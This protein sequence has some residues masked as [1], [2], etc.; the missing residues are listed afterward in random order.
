M[1]GLRL[2]DVGD[3][4]ENLKTSLK[5]SGSRRVFYG[6]LYLVQSVKYGCYYGQEVASCPMKI[7]IKKVIN[8]WILQYNKDPERVF[9]DP[10]DVIR[11]AA[12]IVGAGGCV[13]CDCRP[14]G[15]K[16]ESSSAGK[17]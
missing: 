9:T 15:G 7:L 8:G 3:S 10:E 5:L 13:R 17:T 14:E 2:K 4:F 11:C 12:R 1:A 16:D 6:V